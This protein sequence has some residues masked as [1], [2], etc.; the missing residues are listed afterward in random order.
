MNWTRKDGTLVI[1]LPSTKINCEVTGYLLRC[2][3]RRRKRKIEASSF[4]KEDQPNN[5]KRR[6]EKGRNKEQQLCTRESKKRG[7]WMYK[8]ENHT[9]DDGDD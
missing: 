8:E 3:Q 9:Y 1:N 5:W 7:K 4:I 6:T 2:R